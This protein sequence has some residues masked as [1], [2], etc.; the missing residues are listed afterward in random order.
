[1]TYSNN[2]LFSAFI[3]ARLFRFLIQSIRFIALSRR[4]QNM[5]Q[6]RSIRLSYM[7]RSTHQN[8][9]TRLI[10]LNAF[11]FLFL[12][13]SYLLFLSSFSLA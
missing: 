9:S 7:Y 11:S 5:C 13:S 3:C 12:L 6:N 1:M 10:E 4:R 8:H 2:S